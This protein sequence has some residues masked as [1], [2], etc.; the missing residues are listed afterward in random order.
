MRVLSWEFLVTAS[1]PEFPQSTASL[2]SPETLSSLY[3]F[4]E[5]CLDL[6]YPSAWDLLFLSNYGQVPGKYNSYSVGDPGH[7]LICV[8]YP[9]VMKSF[10][11]THTVSVPPFSVGGSSQFT[12]DAVAYFPLGWRLPLVWGPSPL[13]CVSNCTTAEGVGTVL[14]CKGSLAGLSP[15]KCRR[16]LF[17]LEKR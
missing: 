10:Q 6:L 12:Q 2:L 8:N 3:P 1:D 14:A 11:E 4:Q 16:L 13:A 9:S 7:F 15:R 5:F 17:R